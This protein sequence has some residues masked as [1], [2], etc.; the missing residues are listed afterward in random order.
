MPTI[1]VILN[2]VAGRGAG[3]RTAEVIRHTLTKAKATEGLNGIIEASLDTPAWEAGEPAAGALGLIPI[4]TGND[5]ARCMGVPIGDVATSS[6]DVVAAACRVLAAGRRGWWTL[7]TL[8][9]VGLSNQRRYLGVE[10]GLAHSRQFVYRPWSL[11][12]EVAQ[13]EDRHFDH[14]V[15]QQGRQCPSFITMQ[16]AQ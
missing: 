2:P 14:H 8:L 15:A 12:R 1:K 16:Q 7:G 10:A 3:Q 9:N 13:A 4:G 11:P 6:H 5:F